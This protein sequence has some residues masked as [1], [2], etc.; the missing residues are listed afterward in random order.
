MLNVKI[1]RIK[2]GLILAAISVLLIGGWAM[3]QLFGIRDYPGGQLKIVYRIT[4]IAQATP[5]TA[6][7]E[8]TPESGENFRVRSLSEAIQPRDR[9]NVGL[10]GIMRLG[11]GFRP[12]SGRIDLTPINAL[13]DKEL[14]VGKTYLLPDGAKFEAQEK[15]KIAGVDAI[16]GLYTHP[17][18]PNQRIILAISDLSTRKLLPLPPLLQVEEKKEG[19]ADFQMISKT[20]LIEFSYKR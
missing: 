6:T 10:F 14:E 17:D 12:E 13:A 11:F 15:L 4:T 16:K 18:F 19:A 8:I 20:E 9:I 3:A 7:V 5:A 2:F 1:N